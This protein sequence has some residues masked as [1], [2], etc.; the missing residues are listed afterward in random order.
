MPPF[1]TSYATKPQKGYPGMMADASE[2]N[3]ESGFILDTDAEP[4]F[5]LQRGTADRTF[6]KFTTGT[7]AGIARAHI[8]NA[9]NGIFEQ[10][11][12]I[13][14]ADEGV[15]FVKAGAAVTKGSKVYWNATTKGYQSATASGVLIEGAEFMDSGVLNDIVRIKLRKVPGGFPAP[16]GG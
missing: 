4:G 7:F 3:G 5:P 2:W 10:N 14:V 9:P 13:A 16:A 1:Q 15:I 8:T 11:T 12:M 6:N